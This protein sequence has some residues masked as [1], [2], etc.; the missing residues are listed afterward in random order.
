[1]ARR[2]P[3][4][5]AAPTTSVRQ[6][7]RNFAQKLK[8]PKRIALSAIFLS[9]TT[10]CLAP[11]LA[12]AAGPHDPFGHLDSA[13]AADQDKIVVRGWTADPDDLSRSLT[14]T[15]ILDGVL[16][17]TVV[18]DVSRPDATAARGAGPKAGFATTIT[19]LSGSHRVCASAANIG[20]GQPGSLGCQ[21]V[22]IANLSAAQ[23]ASH[24]PFGMLER[25]TVAGTTVTLT[26][27][28]ADPD[29]ASQPLG[30]TV[31]VD[32]RPAT[33]ARA[34]TSPRADVVRVRHTG[35]DQGY[36]VTT[37]IKTNGSHVVCTRATNLLAGAD[38]QLGC[39]NVRIGPPPLT[40]AQ[41][42]AHSPSGSVQA[43][44][45]EGESNIRIMGWAS[46]PDNLTTP[47]TVVGYL[48]GTRARSVPA[49]LTTPASAV[50]KSI[51]RNAG[52]SFTVPARTGSHIVCVWAV[53]LGIGANRF[54]G[55]VPVSTPAVTMPSGPAP[56][57]PVSNQK[58]T[59]LAIKYLGSKYL[60]GGENPQTG[61]DCSGLVQY[62]YRLGAGI[63][64][65][66]V[67][68]DQFIAARRIAA[69]RAVP[70]DLVFFH[71]DTGSVYHVGILAGPGMMY[72]AVDETEGVRYQ[73]IWDAT[74]TFGS[75][76]HS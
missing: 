12:G 34:T 23:I 49:N 45:A 73:R 37:A 55:C 54:L 10:L 75:F 74:A 64:T 20:A 4:R 57:I 51:G 30:I 60:W 38:T 24:S 61:F 39:A 35:P 15:I 72:A 13:I 50:N 65:P 9:A 44:F 26:G 25:V 29:L 69:A 1:M 43:A 71:D 42:A 28:A 67:A 41:V 2:V 63:A 19:A 70:G 56:A 27:W 53:N 46:D 16:A 21:T 76:T 32:A 36:L 58:V 18:S 5:H 3:P 33:I 14:V 62:T 40:A 68:Q 17:G 47:V 22:V 6:R 31:T 52:F 66:R 11:S 59:A 7:A 48:D 8:A